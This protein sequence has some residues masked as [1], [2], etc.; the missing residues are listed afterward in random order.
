MAQTHDSLWLNLSFTEDFK[1]SQMIA[2][3]ILPSL[4]D[5]LIK[6]SLPAEDH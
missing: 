4:V 1:D 2:D 6:C 5:Q 3:D